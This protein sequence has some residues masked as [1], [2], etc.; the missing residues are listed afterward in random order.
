LLI[1]SELPHRAKTPIFS[2]ISSFASRV[3]YGDQPSE[4]EIPLS[5]HVVAA[6]AILSSREDMFYGLTLKNLSSLDLFPYV[7]YFDPGK[8][9]IDVSRRV[10]YSPN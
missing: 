3:I 10:P 6:E 4:N 9:A 7:F 1:P 8:Y 2:K 5:Q